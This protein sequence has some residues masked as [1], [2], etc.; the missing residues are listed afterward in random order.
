MAHNVIL[1]TDMK[2][3][4]IALKVGNHVML[5]PNFPSKPCVNLRNRHS[6]W[7]CLISHDFYGRRQ[8]VS[9]F[10]CI[11]GLK[12]HFLTEISAGHPQ[13]RINTSVWV[14]APL[15]FIFSSLLPVIPLPHLSH[16]PLFGGDSSA[17]SLL[18]KSKYI[19]FPL[20]NVLYFTSEKK[21]TLILNEG[22]MAVWLTQ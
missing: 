19:K 7:E 16:T 5:S 4:M 9:T 22:S 6:I 18:A 17:T 13:W 10:L 1:Q 20:S 14:H 11:G 12:M 21:Q 2:F 8:A 3:N 15:S